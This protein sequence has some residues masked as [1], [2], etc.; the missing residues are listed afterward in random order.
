MEE[1]EYL[2]KRICRIIF[3]SIHKLALMWKIDRS[4]STRKANEAWDVPSEPYVGPIE[5]N[6]EEPRPQRT[7]EENRNLFNI[8]KRH[9]GIRRGLQLRKANETIS[10][11]CSDS[12]L[13]KVFLAGTSPC[14]IETAACVCERPSNIFWNTVQMSRKGLR[15]SRNLRIQWIKRN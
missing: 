15:D 9:W 6:S 14:L 4:I 3:F 11:W 1:T 13:W 12:Y 8:K 10:F 2:T 5:A 7:S